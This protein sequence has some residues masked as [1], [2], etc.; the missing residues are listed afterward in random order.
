M[1]YRGQQGAPSICL[2]RWQWVQPF[3]HKLGILSC[4]QFATCTHPLICMIVTLCLPIFTSS[5][6]NSC[7]CLPLLIFPFWIY[8]FVTALQPGGCPPPSSLILRD[9]IFQNA[10]AASAQSL[11]QDSRL[12]TGGGGDDG[13]EEW[14]VNLHYIIAASLNCDD[15]VNSLRRPVTPTSIHADFRSVDSAD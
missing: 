10:L 12:Q 15:H 1:K 4:W 5:S 6:Q 13:G 8:K 2:W 11:P 7:F 9:S 14:S 3:H